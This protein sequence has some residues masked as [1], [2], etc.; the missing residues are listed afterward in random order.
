MFDR[1]IYRQEA[2]DRL[3]CPEELDCLFTL[4]C[5]PGWAL[6]ASITLLC[7]GALAWGVFGRIPEIVEGTGI[8]IPVG[9]MRM[10]SDGP[11]PPPKVLAY[12][13]L[14]TGKRVRTG[15][16]AR[17]TPGTH[18]REQNGSFRGTVVY[19][20]DSLVTRDSAVRRIRDPSLASTLALPDV[21]IE[22]EIELELCDDTCGFRANSLGTP[23]GST[24][25]VRVTCAERTPLTYLFANLRSIAL[26]SHL[27]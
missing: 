11:A 12:F 10:P 26:G 23:L 24:L 14:Q 17:V 5:L 25:V 6:P 27:R 4:V 19:V 18:R 21:M 2:L 9:Q 16:T 8:L 7:L 15:M 22:A 3:V 1:Q 13:P 20:S